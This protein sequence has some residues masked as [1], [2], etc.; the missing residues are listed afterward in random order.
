MDCIS[1]TCNDRNIGTDRVHVGD[2]PINHFASIDRE[3]HTG[4]IL[5]AARL[6]KFPIG[7][8]AVENLVS[9]MTI[10]HDGERIVVNCDVWDPML[11]QDRTHYFS[12]TPKS[13]IITLLRDLLPRTGWEYFLAYPSS[14]TC[15][16]CLEACALWQSPWPVV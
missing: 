14:G 15:G 1:S 11:P 8:I 5:Q 13:V 12:N 6:E 16:V 10:A 4:R 3:N 2:D 7:G 9:F